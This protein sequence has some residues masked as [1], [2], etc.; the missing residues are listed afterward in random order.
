MFVKQAKE[1]ARAWVLTEGVRLPGFAGAFHTGST[2]WAPDDDVLPASS[3]V[4]VMV[5]LASAEPPV[6]L[7]KFRHAGVLLEISFMPDEPLASPEDVLGNYHLAGS[8]RFPC[9][10]ADPTGNLTE[11]HRVVARDFA[12]RRWVVARAEHAMAGV[13]GGI[14]RMDESDRLPDQ[15]TAWLFGT[16]ITTHVLLAA[17]LRNPTVRR[18]YEAVRSLLAEHGRLDYHETL[19]ELL[20]CAAMSPARVAH[21]LA[22]LST[23]FDAATAVDAPSFRFSSDI[24]APARPIAID[25]SRELI[26]RGLHRE[27]LFWLVATYCRCLT[28]LSL[29]GA[30][31]SAFGDGLGELLADLGAESSADRRRRGDL[32]L[33]ALPELWQVAESLMPAPEV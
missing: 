25:G 30:D 31:V 4:D 29:A 16:G 8:F 19:L 12:D 6:K 21:H 15:V 33:A 13:R 14:G 20:G 11:I 32:V 10:I 26:A 7:G 1:I 28:K 27:T 5:V 18:R 24:T 17:G 23:V 3:D 9:V 2:L 22:A